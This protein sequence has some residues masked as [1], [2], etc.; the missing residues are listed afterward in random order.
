M[1]VCLKCFEVYVQNT[2]IKKE[3]VVTDSYCLCPKVNCLGEVVELDELITPTII[4]LNK[5]GYYTKF[6]CSGHWYQNKPNTYI[7]FLD[8]C[9]PDIVPEGFIVQ[10]KSIIRSRFEDSNYDS[11]FDFVID[12]N[13]RLY[14]WAKKL[15]NRL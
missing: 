12:M 9:L 2:L 6:C 11:K 5:K 8:N 14:E 13:K 15:E 3:S 10:E 4:E 7:Y 1:L